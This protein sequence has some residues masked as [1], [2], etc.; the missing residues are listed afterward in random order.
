MCSMTQTLSVHEFC[1]FE[2]RTGK[3][4]YG[5]DKNVVYKAC[6]SGPYSVTKVVRP[7]INYIEGGSWMATYMYRYS[8][9]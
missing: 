1:L 3:Y 6:K 2:V 9:S 8:S 5:G 4:M 7:H